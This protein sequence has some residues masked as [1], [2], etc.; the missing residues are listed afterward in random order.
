MTMSKT[1]T[2]SRPHDLRA[3]FGL[4]AV[5]FT[6]ELR[7]DEQL[8]LPMQEEALQGM[9]RTLDKRMSAAIIAPSGSGKTATVRRLIDQLPD[10]RY[11][12]RYVKVTDL[13]KRD[14]CREIAAVCGVSPAGSYPT[15]LR[16]LQEGFEAS[17]DT[18]SLRPV[19]VLD[20]A[21]DLR[22]EVLSMLRVLTNF[23]MDRRLVLSLVLAGQT[24]LRTLLRREDQEAVARR[25]AFYASLRLL[26]DGETQSY[27][28]HRCT[29][30][31]AGSCPFDA[32]AVAA[33]F[34]ISRG[35]LRCIDL[36]CLEALELAASAGHASVSS[37]HVVAARKVL[38]P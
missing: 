31:G 13:S 22:P 23:E 12:V 10:A 34:D 24:P 29:I 17:L 30:A 18:D 3:A 14:L 19:L 16:R 1:A 5:P 2:K 6:R 9:L 25:I 7:N 20:E 11:R 38:W 33:V 36:L 28:E 4:H 21:H 15:L 35:N 8:R 26:S 37:N 27:I 32:S